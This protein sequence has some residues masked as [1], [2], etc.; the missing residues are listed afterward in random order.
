MLPRIRKRLRRIRDVKTSA[1][2]QESLRIRIRGMCFGGRVRLRHRAIEHE[3]VQPR[4]RTPASASVPAAWRCILRRATSWR[5]RA[6]S[7]KGTVLNAGRSG[8]RSGA[9]G[10]EAQEEGGEG[11]RGVRGWEEAVGE[12][13]R[14][15]GRGHRDL[16][17]CSLMRSASAKSGA[18]LPACGRPGSRGTGKNAVR[19]VSTAER[20][21]QTGAGLTDV[22]AV[23]LAC[24][25]TADAQV[26]PEALP[27]PSRRKT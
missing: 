12:G 5:T 24:A 15:G 4:A 22:A 25:C 19:G 26:N 2:R 17:N 14:G 27:A 1:S 23:A 21:A 9:A 16:K 11:T 3:H 8:L 7:T 20:R 10:E 18:P 6:G 13:E